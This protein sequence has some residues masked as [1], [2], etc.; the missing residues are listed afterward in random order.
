MSYRIKSQPIKNHWFLTPWE[1]STW[2]LLVP[3]ISRIN[4]IQ[5][6]N[7][8]WF[9][10]FAPTI[11]NVEHVARLI[12]ISGLSSNSGSSSSPSGCSA[13]RTWTVNVNLSYAIAGLSSVLSVNMTLVHMS[14]LTTVLSVIKQGLNSVVDIGPCM[15]TRLDVDKEFAHL[16]RSRSRG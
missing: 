13:S 12:P 16:W 5:W 14:T 2:F 4:P 9:S 6:L 11:E 7:N 1:P 8:H 3:K 15:P 10:D